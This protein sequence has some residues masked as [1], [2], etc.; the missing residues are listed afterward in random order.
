MK[1]ALA[2]A[3]VVLACSAQ[4]LGY[5]L[6][7]IA[8]TLGLLTSDYGERRTRVEVDNI[9]NTRF[10]RESFSYVRNG[11]RVEISF[12]CPDNADC[13]RPPHLVGT[14]TSSEYVVDQSVISR[15]PLVYKR[16]ALAE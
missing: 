3:L 7:V 11:D 9:G 15:T 16:L 1:R 10:T 4:N 13:I 8:D 12:P 5:P 2:A 14:V 6:R